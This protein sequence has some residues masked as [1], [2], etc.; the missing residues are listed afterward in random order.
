VN[1]AGVPS[2]TLPGGSWSAIYGAN[3]SGDYAGYGDTADGHFRAFV[4]SASSGLTVL[5]TLGGADSWAMALNEEEAVAG[6]STTAS[7]FIHAFVEENG[8]MFDLGTLGGASSYAYGINESGA[9]VG[10]SITPDGSEHAFVTNGGSMMDLNSLVSRDSG[11]LL[12]TAYS[13]DD[14]GRITGAGIL[15]GAMREYRLDPMPG[16]ISALNASL[17]ASVPEPSTT[18]A[19]AAALAL[20]ARVHRSARA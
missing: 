17:S 14:A 6:H 10:Y 9:V 4:W 2:A 11:W 15:N 16:A 19:I 20:L 3:R 1:L 7:G 8:H 18:I 12:T 5:G 13:I